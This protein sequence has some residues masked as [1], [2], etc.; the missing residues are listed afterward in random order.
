MIIRVNKDICTQDHSC[1]AVKICPVYALKQTGFD[2]PTVLE[3]RCVK[4][5]RCVYYCPTGAL[6][7]DDGE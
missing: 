7:F 3:E 6:E 5:G 4:C 1:L 2:A